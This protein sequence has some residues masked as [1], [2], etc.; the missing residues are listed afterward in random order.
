MRGFLLAIIL[1]FTPLARAERP[2]NLTDLKETET[3]LQQ[4]ITDGENERARLW[5][6]IGS[7]KDA[8]AALC[9]RVVALET[10]AD[11]SKQNRDWLM[12]IAAVLLGNIVW[13]FILHQKSS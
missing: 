9:N 3:R 4:G 1:C 7:N 13:T 2:A 6:A 12:G 11:I 5:I 8:D 10:R